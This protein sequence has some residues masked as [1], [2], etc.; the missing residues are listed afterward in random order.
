MLE[1]SF[2]YEHALSCFKWLHN[3]DPGWKKKG[4]NDGDITERAYAPANAAEAAAV[5]AL[6][7]AL[8]LNLARVY[9]KHGDGATSLLAC[10]AALA[11]DADCDKAL[12][13]RAQVR[14]APA[15]AGAVEHE[16]ALK[17]T[18]AAQKVRALP[19]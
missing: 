13:L 2:R 1:A 4:I 17:D 5:A 9:F 11:V 6:L 16:A 15:S 14:V 7:V 10:S 19:C 3:A 18:A 8:Y 12:L